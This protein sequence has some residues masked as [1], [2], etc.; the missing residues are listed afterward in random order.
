[1]AVEFL[2]WILF[3]DWLSGLGVRRVVRPGMVLGGELPSRD[4]RAHRPK[5]SHSPGRSRWRRRYL[6]GSPLP[7]CPWNA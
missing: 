3:C 4:L 1:M 2:W 5:R 6:T 7:T